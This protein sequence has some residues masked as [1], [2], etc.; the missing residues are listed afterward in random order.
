M[1][2][3]H[4]NVTSAFISH[5]LD[6]KDKKP[7]F[8]EPARTQYDVN[9]RLFDF[10]VRIHPF[11]WILAVL[12]GMN[13]STRGL[14]IWVGVVFVSILVHE[15]GHAF[16]IRYFGWSP[17]VVLHGFG[18][19]AIYD[20][21]FS[22]WQ[23]G[24]RAR[25]THASQILISLAGPGAGFALAALVVVLLFL[26]KHS[27]PFWF[28]GYEV[29]LGTGTSLLEESIRFGEPSVATILVFQLLEVNIYWGILNLMPIYP[30]DGGQ[31]ARELL[32]AKSH[33]GVRQSL[34][35]SLATAAVLAAL[36]IFRFDQPYLGLM[37]GY[38]AFMN[39]RQLN[40]PY[41]GF[42]NRPW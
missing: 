15:L 7:M 33:D 12:L 30:L 24:R 34:Q 1:L 17:H 16:V 10:P 42:G 3:R 11:F 4:H 9:F 31:V 28:F 14:L 5:E 2:S 41:R 40:G 25:R 39:Y 13:N 22:P 23:S 6:H 21:N 20:P 18:G 35:L 32:I 8:G 37:F 36:A 27:I 26:T 38:M 29:Q 19:L